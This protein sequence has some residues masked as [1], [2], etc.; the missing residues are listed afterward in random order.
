MVTDRVLREHH[1]SV[2]ADGRDFLLTYTLALSESEKGPFCSIAVLLRERDRQ[3][4]EREASCTVELTYIRLD[5]ATLLFEK[6]S[7][8]FEPLFPAHLPDVVRDQL[9][10]EE[11]LRVVQTE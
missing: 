3:G 7:G 1:R 9:C 11:L 2:L 6:I 5:A 8:A 10:P 4:N